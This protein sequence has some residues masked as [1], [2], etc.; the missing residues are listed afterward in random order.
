MP[1][2]GMRRRTASEAV[3]TAQEPPAKAGRLSVKDLLAR[4]QDAKPSGVTQDSQRRVTPT[5]LSQKA[6][7]PDVTSAG[8]RKSQTG[9]SRTSCGR[10]L[11]QNNSHPEAPPRKATRPGTQL[12]EDTVE[13]PDAKSR[14]RSCEPGASSIKQAAQQGGHS[15]DTPGSHKPSGCQEP[16]GAL[17]KFLVQ[18]DYAGAARLQEEFKRRGLDEHHRPE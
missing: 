15:M 3:S 17:Y 9:T 10:V 5:A 12:Y 14:S 11:K 1:R 16:H 4:S 6:S 2:E 13:T 8:K 7:E 18:K